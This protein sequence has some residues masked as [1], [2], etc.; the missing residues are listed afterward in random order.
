MK[1]LLKTIAMILIVVMFA[2]SVTS[3]TVIGKAT[4]VEEFIVIGVV[5]DV[6]AVAGIIAYIWMKIDQNKNRTASIQKNIST[7]SLT[8]SDDGIG[9]ISNSVFSDNIEQSPFG[10]TFNAL[11]E[12]QID[13]LTQK[14]QAVPETEMISFMETFDTIHQT[15]MISA[16]NELNALSETDLYNTVW[17]LNSLSET[18]FTALLRN[19]K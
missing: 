15:D 18:Q 14:V 17:Y 19:I 5:C 11:P 2:N 16:L 6:L 1:K 10:G 4:G 12:V 9:A 7:A 3:C 13:T 8:I